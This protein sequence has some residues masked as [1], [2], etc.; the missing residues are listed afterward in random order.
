MS[1][2]HCWAVRVAGDEC[3]KPEVVLPYPAT[4]LC[5][6]ALSFH[7]TL[8]QYGAALSIHYT[9]YQYIYTSRVIPS[10]STKQYTIYYI[11][12]CCPLHPLYYILVYIY[13]YTSIYQYSAALSI[14]PSSTTRDAK[15]QKKMYAK[16]YAVFVDKFALSFKKIV[17]SFSYYWHFLT[18]FFYVFE[19]LCSR[20][21]VS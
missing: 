15:A 6:A 2:T 13:Q 14:H 11:V 3:G 16:F 4:I 19:N 18:Q 12:Q 7:Y 17:F 8:Y 10:P 9:I 21:L 20:F 1:S 5:S